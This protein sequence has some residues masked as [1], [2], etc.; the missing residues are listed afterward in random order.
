MSGGNTEA[1]YYEVRV[2]S[3]VGFGKCRTLICP[4]VGASGDIFTYLT[5][6]R[7]VM[8]R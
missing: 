3:S 6:L 4:T 5:L 7:I 2:K 1:Y 8:T